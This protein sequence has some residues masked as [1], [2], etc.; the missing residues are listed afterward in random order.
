MSYGLV[1]LAEMVLEI[2]AVIVVA[3]VYR[4]VIGPRISDWTSGIWMVL[5]YA[6]RIAV[7]IVIIVCIWFAIEDGF[8][9]FSGRPI[10]Y[11]FNLF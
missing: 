7:V 5:A 10:S 4:K 11:L 2:V 1:L 8:Y 9:A 6:I 3:L